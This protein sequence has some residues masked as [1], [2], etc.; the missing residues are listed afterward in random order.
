MV[1]GIGFTIDIDE[2]YILLWHDMQQPIEV[3]D[4]ASTVKIYIAFS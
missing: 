3:A 4:V 2:D 1:I